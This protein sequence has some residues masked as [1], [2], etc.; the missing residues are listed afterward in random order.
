MTMMMIID[1]TLKYIG[2]RVH[3]V[4]VTYCLRFLSI[5][6]RKSLALCC[7]TSYNGTFDVI[8]YALSWSHLLTAVILHCHRPHKFHVMCF[9]FQH[10]KVINNLSEEHRK[11][12][13]TSAIIIKWQKKNEPHRWR[14]YVTMQCALVPFVMSCM[15]FTLFVTWLFYEDIFTVEMWEAQVN[16]LFDSYSA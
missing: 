3:H 16:I 14:W 13:H 10:A 11:S 6:L 8:K 9:K 4:L 5:F 1:N 12:V 7:T 2:M 15:H